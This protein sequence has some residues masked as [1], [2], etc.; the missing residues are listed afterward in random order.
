MIWR[1]PAP[2]S[3]GNHPKPQVLEGFLTDHKPP[4][5]LTV[6]TE[7]PYEGLTYPQWQKALSTPSDDGDELHGCVRR[8]R[9]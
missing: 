3:S 8:E 5:E 7:S 9:P 6:A 4:G 1:M 2:S